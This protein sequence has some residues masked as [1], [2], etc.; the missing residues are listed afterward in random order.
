[1]KKFIFSLCAITVILLS[2]SCEKP[3]ETYSGKPSIYF[4]EAAKAVTAINPLKDS[5]IVSFSLAKS[6]DSIIN[7]VIATT[8]ELS[9]QERPYK[10]MVNPN[11]TAIAGTHYEIL[12]ETFS[13]KKNKALDTVQIKIFRTVD[14]QSQ[15]FLLS[16]DLHDNDQF[17]TMMTDKFVTTTGITH[18]YVNYRWFLN[19]IVKKPARWLDAYLGTFSRKK[20]FLMVDVL[21]VDPVRLDNA[22]A[23]AELDAYGKFMQR[24]LNEQRAAGNN[25][26]EDDDS[27][28]IMGPSA[29]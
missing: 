10:L 24:Y 11:S 19:D 5:T 28:M 3:L 8:G 9:T 6:R 16:F 18:S 23:I 17:T 13:I 4:N 14:M 12:T 26:L 27:V 21:G 1:M 2:P 25:I 7:M 22:V 20:L 15:T 29:Q